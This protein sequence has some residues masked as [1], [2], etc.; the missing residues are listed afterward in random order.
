VYKY[1]VEPVLVARKRTAALEATIFDDSQPAQ[2]S[3]PAHL[4]ITVPPDTARLSINVFDRFGDHVRRLSTE[5]QPA[6]GPRAVEWDV[7]NDNGEP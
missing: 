6:S 2:T 1:S 4:H 3:R 7:T 5:N